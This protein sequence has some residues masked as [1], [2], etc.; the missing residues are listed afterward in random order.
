MSEFIVALPMY[1]WPEARS[2]VDAEWTAMRDRLRH[3]G[4]DAPPCLV[5]RNADMPAVPGG[6]RDADGRLIAPDPATLPPD[7]LDMPTLWRHPSLLLAQTCWGPLELGLSDHVT[8]VGQPSYDGIEGGEGILYSSAILMRRGEGHESDGNLPTIGLSA[9]DDEPASAISHAQPGPS[10]GISESVKAPR[11]G[12]PSLPLECMAGQRLALNSPDSMSGL[13]AL[14]RDLEAA[15]ESLGVF[16]SQV[17]TG[18]HRASIA[19]VASG[20]ADVCA[21]DCRSWRLAERHEPAAEAVFVIGWTGRRK[22]LPMV[23]SNHTSPELVRALSDVLSQ[24]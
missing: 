12:S 22:G 9:C 18:S 19:A 13:L 24:A 6:I 1:D 3:A 7:S 5:R 2:E 11:D 20:R 10:A 8:V 15:G 14:R 21:I 16:S 23:T 17:V 4:I